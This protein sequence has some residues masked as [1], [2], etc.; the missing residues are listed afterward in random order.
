MSLT[1][2]TGRI[3]LL[4]YFWWVRFECLPFFFLYLSNFKVRIIAS[5]KCL[6]ENHERSFLWPSAC[7]ALNGNGVSRNIFMVDDERN[8]HARP[9]AF[10]VFYF[11]NS[12]K[13][14]ILHRKSSKPFSTTEILYSWPPG[15]LSLC[16]LHADQNVLRCSIRIAP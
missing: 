9:L 7:I 8:G 1:V 5:Q 16:Q 10:R 4:V 12:N 13:F 3:V 6:L 11:I 14:S 2:I 15:V